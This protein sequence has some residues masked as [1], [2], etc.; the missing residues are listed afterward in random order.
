MSVQ[1]AYWKDICGAGT[2]ELKMTL[3]VADRMKDFEE[4]IFQV[5]K[6]KKEEVEKSGRKVYNLSVGTPDFP[7]E[8]H[9]I[10]AVVEAAKKPANYKYALK[11]LTEL[12]QAVI[13][14]FEK[15]YHPYRDVSLQSGRY[16]ACAR[17]GL[18][19]LFHRPRPC[20][21]GCENL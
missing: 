3:K 17:P 7:T 21:G 6:E 12:T 19:G 15:R 1:K 18:S 11:M 5:L 16:C 9:V 8:P 2:G 13:N 4:G 20:N 10:E 14:R